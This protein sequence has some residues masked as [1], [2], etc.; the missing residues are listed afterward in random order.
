[1]A[2][3]QIWPA[4]MI[5]HGFDADMFNARPK[6]FQLIGRHLKLCP[7]VEVAQM[8]EQGIDVSIVVNAM[9]RRVERDAHNAF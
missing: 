3:C 1:M 4:A 8:C 9:Q 5:N 7:H 2:I 6:N